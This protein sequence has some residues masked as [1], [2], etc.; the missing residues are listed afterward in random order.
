VVIQNQLF[1]AT[2]IES[3]TKKQKWD[4]D[5]PQAK[6]CDQ[7]MYIS[8]GMS[9]QFLANEDIRARSSTPAGTDVDAELYCRT[10]RYPALTSEM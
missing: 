8:T 6:L 9:T 2:L 1:Q 5:T 3:M 10:S 4:A 7:H